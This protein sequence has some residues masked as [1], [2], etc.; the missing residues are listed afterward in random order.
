[1]PV[2][3][4]IVAIGGSDPILPFFHHEITLGVLLRVF[5]GRLPY[6]ER[7]MV[8]VQLSNDEAPWRVTK[9]PLEKVKP[10]KRSFVKM[11]RNAP[12]IT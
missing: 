8:D 5:V 7:I 10:T 1:M 11:T 2:P 6:L 3:V 4:V 9:S 12:R